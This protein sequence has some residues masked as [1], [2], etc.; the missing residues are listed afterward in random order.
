MFRKKKELQALVNASRKALA[1]AEEKIAERNKLLQ[2][3]HETIKKL[4][5]KMV[6]LENNIEF[7]TNNSRNKKLQPHD[8]TIM[9]GVLVATNL[10]LKF[11][12]HE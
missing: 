1:N 4:Q 9:G 11:V 10:P 6:D 5:S 8:F 2:Y 12:K 7:L 3:Q